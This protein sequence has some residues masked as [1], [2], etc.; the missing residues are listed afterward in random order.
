[1]TDQ[2]TLTH[3]QRMRI[4]ISNEDRHLLTAFC[5]YMSNKVYGPSET[6]D[7]YHHFK[8]GYECRGI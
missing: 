4:D 3:L 1:M 7:V 2:Q 5:N 8:A 6:L